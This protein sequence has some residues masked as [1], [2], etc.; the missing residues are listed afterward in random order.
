MESK[1]SK[2]RKKNMGV[3]LLLLLLIHANEKSTLHLRIIK[4]DRDTRRERERILFLPVRMLRPTLFH[5]EQV[6]H[7]EREEKR[8][9]KLRSF[10]NKHVTIHSQVDICLASETFATTTTV[11]SIHPFY[12]VRNNNKGTRTKKYNKGE[13]KRRER[14]RERERERGELKVIQRRHLTVDVVVVTAV[15]ILSEKERACSA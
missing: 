12:K 7:Q 14:K 2:E 9:G 1:K 11:Q 13:K 10:E 6:F 5:Q 4:E 8:K 3:V 15:I